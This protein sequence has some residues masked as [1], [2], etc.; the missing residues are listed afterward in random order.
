[1]NKLRLIIFISVAV[2]SAAICTTAQAQSRVFV[3]GLGDDLNPCT[4][5]APCRNFQ[6]AHD[7][8]AADGEVVALDSAGYGAVAI[9]K[10]VTLDGAGQH[11]GI[12]A[13]SGAAVTINAASAKVVLRD[14]T[15]NG[16]GATY[17]INTTVVG[18]LHIEGCI[19][20]GFSITGIFVNLSGGGS[21]YIKDTIARNNAS[22]GIII[23]TSTGTV[24]AS[25]D[26]CRAENN[27]NGGGF[28]AGAGARV[29]VSHSVAAGNGSSGFLASAGSGETAAMNA[30]HCVA[31]NND[32]GF[33]SS[34]VAGT[35][36]MRVGRSTAT[37]NDI[38]FRQFTSVGGIST[39][40]SLGD[41]LVRGNTIID[42]SGMIT[43]VPGT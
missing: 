21:I 29:T 7:V 14:L 10:S 27:V 17:G 20:N 16:A 26:H 34:G 3:S 35:A 31:S 23:E 12:T 9:T 37:N 1:V 11:A 19:V 15:L 13:P 41:N 30:D 36:T 5:T 25:V 38:G 8:V 6:R 42:T 22:S 43:T 2:I 28:V 4:R 40:E 24:E 32:H 39:F 18:V 33:E